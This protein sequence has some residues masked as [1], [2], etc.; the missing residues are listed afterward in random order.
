[1]LDSEVGLAIDTSVGSLIDELTAGQPSLDEVLNRV[2]DYAVRLLDRVEGAS[3]TI[4]GEDMKPFTMVASDD[5]V[6]AVDRVQYSTQQG[7]CIEVAATSAPTSGSADLAVSDHWPVFGPRAAQLGVGAI[8]AAGLSAHPDPAKADS[9]PGALNLYSRESFAFEARDRD[10]AVLIAAIAG[11]AVRLTQARI[12]AERLREA[13]S[14]R[15]V[16]GQAKGILMERHGLTEERAFAM[17][18]STSNQLNV[19]LRVVAAG[20]ASAQEHSAAVL[21]R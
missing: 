13:L 15:D 20:L 9:P 17:L 8:L 19:K 14:S 4:F 12:T 21:D 6:H 1:M 2:V 7:P 11:M 18:R 3:I 16:I 10:Q 5:W